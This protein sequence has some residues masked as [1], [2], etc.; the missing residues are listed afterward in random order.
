MVEG[1]GGAR[2][3]GRRGMLGMRGCSCENKETLMSLLTVQ[4][5][6]LWI[7][8]AGDSSE[9][10]SGVFISDVTYPEPGDEIGASIVGISKV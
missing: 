1:I 7:I 6:Y 3:G 10:I 4:V 5:L 2:V 9:D 8:T